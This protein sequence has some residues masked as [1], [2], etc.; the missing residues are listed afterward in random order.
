MNGSRLMRS[1][2]TWC[3]GVP[4]VGSYVN[5]E[6]RLVKIGRRIEYTCGVKSETIKLNRIVYLRCAWTSFL[7]NEILG[8]IFQVS[9]EYARCVE[10]YHISTGYRIDSHSISGRL[11]IY[12]TKSISRESKSWERFSHTMD[13]KL[14]NIVDSVNILNCFVTQVS[15]EPEIDKH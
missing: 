1:V 5:T 6:W 2:Y 15:G 7:S 11:Q 4:G 14:F 3:G 10:G 8:C 12:Y 9:L 13:F